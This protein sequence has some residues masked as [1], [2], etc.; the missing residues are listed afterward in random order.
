MLTNAAAHL[1]VLALSTCWP[2]VT[3]A[4]FTDCN[5]LALHPQVMRTVSCICN[6]F[7]ISRQIPD[8][9]KFI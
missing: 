6:E 1:F 8:C 7:T 2:F 4:S 5:L 3:C 9:V